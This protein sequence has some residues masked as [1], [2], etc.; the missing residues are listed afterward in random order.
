MD[1]K[2]L[3]QLYNRYRE[4]S[5]PEKIGKRD[6]TIKFMLMLIFALRIVSYLTFHV[7]PVG[8]AFIQRNKMKVKA[9]LTPKAFE[10]IFFLDSG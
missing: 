4:P 2:K 1:R 6:L 7:D 8:S 10:N 3:E 5:E 9:E